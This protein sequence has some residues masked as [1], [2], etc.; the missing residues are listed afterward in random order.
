MDRIIRIFGK[1]YGSVNQAALLLGFFAFLSQI[2]ALFRDRFL[3]HFIGPTS[4]LDVYYAAFRVP[5]LIFISIASLAS[6]TVIIPFIAAKMPEGKIT[7]EA[8]KLLNDIFTV[9][10]IVMLAVSLAAFFLMPYLAPLIAP[11]FTAPMQSKMIELSRIMLFSPILLGLSN[12]FGTVTQLF[13]RFFIYALSPI[14]YNVGIILG[15]IF[16]YPTFGIKGLAFGV[17]LGALMHFGIQALASNAFHFT[18]KFS[19]GR[20]PMGEAT[21][22]NFSGIKAIALTSFPRTL[23][24]SL[25]SIAL[26]SIIA[27]A[28]YLEGGS[29]SIFNL[30]LNLQSVPLN[31]IGISYA[32]AA[33]PTLA[34]SVSL[35]KL[36]EFRN[37]LKEAARA[38]IFWS[39]PI[40]FLFIVLRAQIVRVILGSGSFSWDNTRLVAASLA[41]FSVSVIAQGMIALLSR[42]YY[43]RGETKTPLLINLFC[44]ILIIILS[45]VFVYLFQNIPLL[46]YFI[47]SLLKVTDIPGTEVLMLPLAYSTGTIL[48]FILYWFFVRRDFMK[49]ESFITKTFFQTLGASFFLGLA[50]YLGLNILSP[51]FGTTTFWGVFLQGFISGILGILTAII[52]LYLLKNEELEDITKTLKTKFWY[53]KILAPSQEGL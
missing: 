41:I 49:G 17:L 15:V 51:I 44:S 24:L 5:D 22:I 39:L 29:I 27:L 19:L 35:G 7:D 8:R 4:S 6:V 23:G 2:L 38:V 42:A 47:E 21:S 43:A 26:I 32:V 13:R 9:F 11:G 50:A 18:P 53:A 33:F 52:V 37:H 34:K 25:N 28:S 3:A 48:N 40:T 14:L 31:I 1:E 16:L 36:D 20:G 12:L 45:Y 46:R 10:F 30:S